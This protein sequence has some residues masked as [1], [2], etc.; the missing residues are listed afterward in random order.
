MSSLLTAYNLNIFNSLRIKLST[1]KVKKENEPKYTFKK[2]STQSINTNT[3]FDDG[4]Y[5]LPSADFP[6]I[7]CDLFELQ[8]NN[9]SYSISQLSL[10][11][12]PLVPLK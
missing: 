6:R 4:K 7:S 3:Y 1:A 12:L 10:R 11:E 2:Q 5:A 9:S 8:K